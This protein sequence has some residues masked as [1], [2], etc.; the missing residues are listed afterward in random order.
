MFC[1]YKGLQ[2]SRWGIN[3][4]GEWINFNPTISVGRKTM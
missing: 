2:D 3:M 1:E 4:H